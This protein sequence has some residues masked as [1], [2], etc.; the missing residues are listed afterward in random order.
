MERTRAFDR[1]SVLTGALIVLALLLVIYIPV[2]VRMAREEHAREVPAPGTSFT[3]F[4]TN[5]L[6]GYREPCG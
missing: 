2:R 4:V 3:L 5:R 6:G 1:R